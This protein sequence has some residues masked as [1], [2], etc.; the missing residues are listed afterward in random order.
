MHSVRTGASITCVCISLICAILFA[1]GAIAPQSSA[2]AEDAPV[3]SRALLLAL[4]LT[5]AG[6][7]LVLRKSDTA[8]SLTALGIFVLGIGTLVSLITLATLVFH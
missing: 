7:S 1:W 8:P 5:A 4:A 3:E 6:G 2:Y